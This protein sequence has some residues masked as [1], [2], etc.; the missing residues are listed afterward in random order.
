MASSLRPW[1]DCVRLVPKPIIELAKTTPGIVCNLRN[2][3]RQDPLRVYNPNDSEEVRL[4]KIRR[5]L[6]LGHMDLCH[7]N[8]EQFMRGVTPGTRLALF[9]QT[10]YGDTATLVVKMR[11]VS[12]RGGRLNPVLDFPRPR[13]WQKMFGRT[14]VLWGSF[15]LAAAIMPSNTP[16]MA[17]EDL[18]GHEFVRL[19]TV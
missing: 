19:F 17:V 1:D 10:F 13:L 8:M 3:Q 16:T 18:E 6:N 14:T 4:H 2:S 12:F 9:L 7:E 15:V 11:E 5:L